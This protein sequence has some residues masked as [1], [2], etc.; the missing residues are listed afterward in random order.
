MGG[1]V[2][3]IYFTP[4]S[5]NEVSRVA[6][7]GAATFVVYLLLLGGPFSISVGQVLTRALRNLSNMTVSCYTNLSSMVLYIPI[8]LLFHIDV[9]IFRDFDALG[10]T[11]MLIIGAIQ[12]IM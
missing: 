3:I 12:V 7:L 5:E 11:I 2:L 1:A 6:E 8:A 4:E 9:L 10:V